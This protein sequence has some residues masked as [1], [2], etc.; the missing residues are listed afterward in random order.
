VKRLLVPVLA[1]AVAGCE[2]VPLGD[3]DY[4]S[5]DMQELR[6]NV[7]A[8]L[9]DVD[10]VPL[11]RSEHCVVTAERLFDLGRDD[12]AQNRSYECEAYRDEWSK[13]VT[14]Y[15]RA[16]IASLVNHGT[17]PE[18]EQM[19]GSRQRLKALFHNP[20]PLRRLF[21]Q[22]LADEER[23]LREQGLIKVKAIILTPLE[24]GQRCFRKD[25]PEF[26]TKKAALS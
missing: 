14:F 18:A 1:I 10:D 8:C 26:R 4:V 24:P 25:Y 21:N 3:P 23:D 2:P 17:T 6:N 9:S 20:K 16:V 22:C 5:P 11:E 19:L 12:C 15:D 7:L 13:V